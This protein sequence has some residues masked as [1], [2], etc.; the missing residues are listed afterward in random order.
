ME[1][2]LGV[3]GRQLF[4]W[5]HLIWKT[6]NMGHWC[7]VLLYDRFYGRPSHFDNGFINLSCILYQT[8]TKK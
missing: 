4:V 1:E 5:V 6:E 7:N 2:C 8:T 3:N